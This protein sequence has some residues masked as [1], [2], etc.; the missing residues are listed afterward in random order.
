MEITIR[1]NTCKDCRHFGHS[2]AFTVGG[3]RP[4]C[5]HRGACYGSHAKE[6]LT[7]IKV[8]TNTGMSIEDAEKY[9]ARAEREDKEEKCGDKE[10]PMLTLSDYK[11]GDCL[12]WAHRVPFT[13]RNKPTIPNWCPLK[14]GMEY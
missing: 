1:I 7:P 8:M 9:V 13:N 10:I 3:S 2:G 6:G 14:N 12:H 11:K 4:V 5:R